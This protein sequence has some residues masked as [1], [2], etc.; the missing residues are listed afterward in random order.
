[1]PDKGVIEMDNLL[2]DDI[3]YTGRKPNRRRINRKGCR[4]P[5]QPFLFALSS[6][7][8]NR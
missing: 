7:L 2:A 1:M 4:K 5:R 8:Y 6:Q 3:T